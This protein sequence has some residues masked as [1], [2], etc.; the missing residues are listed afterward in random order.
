M[1]CWNRSSQF[2]SPCVLGRYYDTADTF[3]QSRSFQKEATDENGTTLCWIR[4]PMVDYLCV[5]EHVRQLQFI[6]PQL[7][8]L[9]FCSSGLSCSSPN[10]LCELRSAGQIPQQTPPEPGRSLR[11]SMWLWF[12]ASLRCLLLSSVWFWHQKHYR[13]E[14]LTEQKGLLSL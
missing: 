13:N 5:S 1:N 6:L 11:Y 8:E 12:V 2:L 3:F 7:C 9:S 14:I 10:W 4:P